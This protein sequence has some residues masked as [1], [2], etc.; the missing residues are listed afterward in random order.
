MGFKGS[1]WEH[2]ANAKHMLRQDEA[3]RLKVYDDATALEVKAPIGHL[4]IGTGRNL[5]DCGISA[6]EADLMLEND[7]DRCVEFLRVVFGRQ[8]F[9]T[10]FT[11]RKMALVNLV[12]NMGGP[13]FLSFKKAVQAIKDFRWND[14]AREFLYN[15]KDGVLEKTPYYLAVGAR[16]ERVAMILK[17]E[18]YPYEDN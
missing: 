16:A 8:W 12:F 14:A 3:T 4:T 9:Q 17:D 18:G 7:I 2:I 5:Q 11:S 10:L 13:R 1:S 15:E 6:D